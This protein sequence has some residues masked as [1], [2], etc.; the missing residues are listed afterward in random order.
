[1]PVLRWNNFRGRL[2]TALSHVVWLGVGR[3][4]GGRDRCFGCLLHERL[5]FC[6]LQ[7]AKCG[8]HQF[9]LFG[10]PQCGRRNYRCLWHPAKH[11]Q[12]RLHP[13]ARHNY[14][15]SPECAPWSNP[16]CRLDELCLQAGQRKH[17][18]DFIPNAELG[19]DCDLRWPSPNPYY[20]DN[21]MPRSIFANR[22]VTNLVQTTTPG[23]TTTTV[24]ALL[25]TTELI[26]DC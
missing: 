24:R 15:S 23:Q 21:G 9:H 22:F 1:V 2:S 11:G 20:D 19:P 4:P 18:S 14:G 17:A 8:L 5:F 26:F 13:S 3:R 6:M 16:H 25:T 10:Q 7:F 12:R